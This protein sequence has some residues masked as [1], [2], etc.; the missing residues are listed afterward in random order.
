LVVN[1]RDKVI[2]VNK[3]EAN[4]VQKKVS[5]NPH[6]TETVADKQ[7]DLLLTSS[8]AKIKPLKNSTLEAGPG[9]ESARGIW[10]AIHDQAKAGG[11]YRI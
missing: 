11:G 8:G 6:Q 9:A 1:G 4:E 10:S 5:W 3:L 2:C 7:V